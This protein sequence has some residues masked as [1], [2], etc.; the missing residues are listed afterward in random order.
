MTKHKSGAAALILVVLTMVTVL[1][2]AVT[3]ASQSTIN[4]R[5]AAYSTQ[6]D[7]ALACAQA[8]IEIGLANTN[9]DN[10]SFEETKLLSYDGR[11]LCTYDV[12]SG[13]MPDGTKVIPAHV[14]KENLTQQYNTGGSNDT[15]TIEFKPLGS[16]EKAS[17]AVYLYDLQGGNELTRQMIYCYRGGSLPP[18]DFERKT[19]N[20][21]GVCSLNVPLKKAA[22][23]RIRPLYTDMQIRITNFPSQTGWE[24]VSVGTA[25]KSRRTIKAYKFYSQLPAAFDE[26]IV[27]F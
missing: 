11:D 24:I 21:D 14:V 16:D 8:G 15:I 23:L 26:A 4:L 20:G 6:N 5:D 2:I 1:G 22:Y 10:D 13:S 12:Q 18:D 25:G 7:Q 9:E 27:S 3:S 17:I 19:A